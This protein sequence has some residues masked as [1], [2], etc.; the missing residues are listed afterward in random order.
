[1]ALVIWQLIRDLPGRAATV[2]RVALPV[3][4]L[5]EALVG[6]ATGIA[7]DAGSAATAYLIERRPLPALASA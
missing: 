2:A 6:I 3:Y 5:Y 4:G 7:A 1:M